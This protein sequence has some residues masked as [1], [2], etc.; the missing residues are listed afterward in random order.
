LQDKIG[1]DG[2]SLVTDPFD[3]AAT[4]LKWASLEADLVTV[5]H[6]HHDHNYL[7]GIKGKPF[8]IDSAGEYEYKGIYVEGV[9]AWH[10]QEQGGRRGPT[11][12]YRIE[13]DDLTIAHLGDLGTTLD[14]KQIE[15]LEGT[16]IL[17]VP[18]GG[19]YTL[20]ARLAVEVIN[21][22]EPR[23]IIPMHYQVSGLKYD[24]A[25]VDKFIKELGLPPRYEDKLKISKKD[26]PVEDSELVI[27]SL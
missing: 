22:L 4:G 1:T 15:H 11:V 23:I 16:D 8:V 2:V 14:A 6:Q 10:D 7:K 12:I 19:K 13:I 26:L 5:S 24:L 17:I 21:Q 20:D 9:D 27:L 3:P 25:P 18:V